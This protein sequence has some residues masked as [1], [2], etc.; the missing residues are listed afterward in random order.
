MALR[1]TEDYIMYYTMHKPTKICK[2]VHVYMY[3]Y[4]IWCGVYGLINIEILDAREWE[5]RD[6]RVLTFCSYLHNKKMIKHTLE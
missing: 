2:Y 5:K 6:S 4:I 1:K 3:M